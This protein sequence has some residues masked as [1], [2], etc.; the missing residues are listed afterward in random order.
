MS[1]LDDA[2]NIAS[3]SKKKEKWYD[4]TI[5]FLSSDLGDDVFKTSK[6]LDISELGLEDGDYTVSVSLQDAGKTS[7]KTPAELNIADGTAYLTLEFNS[8][9]YSY[10]IVDDVK[11][12]AEEGKDTS[13][14]VVPVHKLDYAFDF[15]ANSTAMGK[16]KERTFKLLIDSES[17]EVK[18]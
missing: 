1:A 5:V 9:N 13:V 4:R 17:I 3:F 15:I 6:G 14:F 8:G 12:E 2:V 10:V 7:V 16:S 18:Q 11:A